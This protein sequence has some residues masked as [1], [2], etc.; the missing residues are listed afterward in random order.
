MRWS[1]SF[2]KVHMIAATLG[3]LGTAGTFFAYLMVS[4][5]SLAADSSRYAMLN[6]VGGA[7]GGSACVVYGAWPSVA[8]NFVWAAVGGITLYSALRTKCLRPNAVPL[9]EAG[10]Q[11]LS[12]VA[13]PG[14][15]HAALS[16]MSR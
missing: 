7:L 2:E 8:S 11:E 1:S 10:P 14:C 9:K 16:P 13:P 15:E 6:L 5:G 12:S 3:W 4:R